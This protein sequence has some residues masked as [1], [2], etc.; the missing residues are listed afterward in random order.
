MTRGT[1][2]ALGGAERRHLAGRRRY[3]C[4]YV[5]RGRVRSGVGTEVEQGH[6]AGRR[7]FSRYMALV[8]TWTETG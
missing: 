1:G 5:D 7:Y 3:F 8:G 6:V 4:R 2:E